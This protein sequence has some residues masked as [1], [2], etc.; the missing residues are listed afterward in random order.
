[1]SHWVQKNS[2]KGAIKLGNRVS[3][4]LCTRDIFV[5]VVSVIEGPGYVGVGVVGDDHAVRIERAS[6]I[7]RAGPEDVLER[8]EPEGGRQE[9]RQSDA[10]LILEKMAFSRI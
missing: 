1:M 7:F 9:R 8:S 2:T 10:P 3:N 6:G 5:A 4:A